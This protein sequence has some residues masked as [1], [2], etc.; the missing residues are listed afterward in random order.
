MAPV[1]L[2]PRTNVVG[3][4]HKYVHDL[5]TYGTLLKVSYMKQKKRI[6]RIESSLNSLIFQL[7]YQQTNLI[8]VMYLT[9]VVGQIISLQNA[10]G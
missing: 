5:V 7:G 8:P 6:F 9:C 4:Q 2:L 1:L 3:S 10:I